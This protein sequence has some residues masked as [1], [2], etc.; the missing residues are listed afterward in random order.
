LIAQ[1]KDWNG[2]R[3]C[4]PPAIGGVKPRGK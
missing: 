3:L 4:H 2:L 1:L